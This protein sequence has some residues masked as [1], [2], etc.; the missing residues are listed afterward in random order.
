MTESE[1]NFAALSRYL[2]RFSSP[3]WGKWKGLA[4]NPLVGITK[5]DLK[6]DCFCQIH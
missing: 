1:I 3:I 5:A 6:I 2:D 4:Y